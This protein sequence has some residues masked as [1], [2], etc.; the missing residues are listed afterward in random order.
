DAFIGGAALSLPRELADLGIATRAMPTETLG[1]PVH[2][3]LV[4]VANQDHF[5][6]QKDAIRAF[7]DALE[8]ATRWII[9]HPAESWEIMT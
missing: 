2:D 5:Q 8:D 7:V 1:I 9:D 6:A 3:G 4:V